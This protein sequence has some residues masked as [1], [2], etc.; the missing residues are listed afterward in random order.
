MAI[1]ASTLGARNVQLIYSGIW[2]NIEDDNVN[3][4]AVDPVLK[5]ADG[6]V[7]TYWWGT[8]P[9]N[10]TAL[11]FGAMCDAYG[12]EY[13]G[14]FDEQY[15]VVKDLEP[16]QTI[17][18]EVRMFQYDGVDTMDYDAVRALSGHLAAEAW[19]LLSGSAIVAVSGVF[20]V[21]VEEDARPTEVVKGIYPA[22]IGTSLRSD[23]G[24]VPEPS[25]Y[26]ALVGL[27]I[28]G[29]AALRR[30]RR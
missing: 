28:L 22:Y 19:D 10:L 18:T 26:A 5:A 23:Y 7:S 13:T 21:T 12:A 1:L 15:F 29:V 14:L 17:Y 20:A 3:G 6:Y 25:T 9:D 16:F 24:A 4:I 30:R 8:T 2:I 27:A 11:G